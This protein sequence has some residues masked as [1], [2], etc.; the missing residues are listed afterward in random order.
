MRRD[1]YLSA[2][3]MQKI[4]EYAER[5]SREMPNSRVRRLD[6]LCVDMALQTGLRVC[7]LAEI[8]VKDIDIERSSM[9]VWRKKK[10]CP[11]RDLL[12][13]SPSLL[14]H[15]KDHLE[16]LKG[17]PDDS[18]WAGTRGPW[19]RVGLQRSWRRTAWDC[20]FDASI[21][22]ARHT[23]ATHLLRQTGNLRM[24]QKQLGHS[25][26]VV[27]ANMYADVPFEDMV[28]ALKGVFG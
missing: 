20:G 26:P 7:E 23:L 22:K 14:A 18:I 16:W 8:K 2:H 17:E 12:G 11:T 6:W 15:L 27:T 3:E 21:H 1:K 4:M 10:R 19:S 13:I 25:S 24:V 28:E 5:M 9:W